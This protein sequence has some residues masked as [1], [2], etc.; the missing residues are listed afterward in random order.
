MENSGPK[1]LLRRQ[2]TE[3]LKAMSPEDRRAESAAIVRVVENHPVWRAAHCVALYAPLPGEVDVWPLVQSGIA[4][5]KR[6]ALPRRVADY[7]LYEL[8]E[9]FE[10][11]RDCRPGRFGIREPRG[12]LPVIEKDRIGLI[13]VPGLGFDHAGRRLGRGKGHYDRLV[14][15]V[16]AVLCGVAFSRQM[17]PAIP[18]ESHDVSMK[19]VVTPE[20]WFE[21][22]DVHSEK[23]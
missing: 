9:V 10:G 19:C 18:V 7:D 17:V 22:S 4:S 8:V 21:S 12:N 11:D 1:A 23:R 3:R 16:T 5:K 15:G 6:V 2:I 14:R 13:F 20:G